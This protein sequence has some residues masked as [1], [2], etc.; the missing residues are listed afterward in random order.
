MRPWLSRNLWETRFR[1]TAP[2]LRSLGAVQSPVPSPEDRG[3][4]P[5]AGADASLRLP[6]RCG[7]RRE[8]GPRVP[9]DEARRVDEEGWALGPPAL[10]VGGSR[11]REWRRRAAQRRREPQGSP[12]ARARG[13][14]LG[15]ATSLRRGGAPD[16][17]HCVLALSR[18]RT[19]DNPP[20][21]GRWLCLAKRIS[22]C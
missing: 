2:S 13:I 3:R 19:V 9:P 10:L 15:P 14:S 5:R 17:L 4:V 21:R 16:P 18:T 11:R 20:P 1:A 8:E 7:T 12:V 22:L 6:P